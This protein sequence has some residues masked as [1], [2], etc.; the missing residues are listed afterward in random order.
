LKTGAPSDRICLPILYLYKNFIQS[1][2]NI[3]ERKKP[4]PATTKILITLKTVNT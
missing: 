2:V 4:N 1:G 3:S